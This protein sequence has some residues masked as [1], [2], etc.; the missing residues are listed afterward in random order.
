MDVIFDLYTEITSKWYN[1]KL[2]TVSAEAKQMI[3]TAIQQAEYHLTRNGMQLVRIDYIE[4]EHHTARY[5]RVK[6]E[7]TSRGVTFAES[8]LYHGTSATNAAS[9]LS[10]N[11]DT[12]KSC[13]GPSIWFGIDPYVSLSYSMKWGLGIDGRYV[14]IASR[15]LLVP[16]PPG[17]IT[18]GGYYTLSSWHDKYGYRKHYW[19]ID[20]AGGAKIIYNT[21]CCC[22]LVKIAF[23]PNFTS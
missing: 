5:Q 20:Q 10:N 18:I 9:I 12:K 8:I 13:S 22:P 17:P 2:L 14:M 4:Q 7:L 15:V 21:D 19:H 11:F 16:P 1:D 6:Q 3:N 23:R